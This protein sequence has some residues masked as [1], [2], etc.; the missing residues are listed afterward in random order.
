MI[1]TN[2]TQ[3][4]A[5]EWANAKIDLLEKYQINKEVEQVLEEYEY[6]FSRE[7]NIHDLCHK[8]LEGLQ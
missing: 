1:K 3:D 2:M 7:T 6:R 5:K 8:T 4:T